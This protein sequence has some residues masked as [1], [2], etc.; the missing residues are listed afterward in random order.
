MPHQIFFSWQSDTRGAIGRFLIHQALGDAI[1]KLKADA[2]IDAAHRE[3]AVDSDT[4][5]IGGSPP[6]VETIFRKIDGALLFVS[7]MTYVG[8]RPGGGGTPNPNV[9][10]EHGWAL[11]S[12]TW[13][14]VISVMNTAM[15]HPKTHELP[16]DLRHA[17][18]PIFFD[19][20]HDA[21]AEQRRTAKDGLTRD[22]AK[23]IR[24]V[25]DDPEV[26]AQLKPAAPVEPHPHDVGLL[27]RA[28]RQFPDG[29]RD[30]L[31]THN[32][33][34]PYR[35]ATVEPLFEMTATWSGAR[36]EFH[37]PEVQAAFSAMRAKAGAFE[38]LLLERTH[39]MDRN[40]EMA[41]PR[42]DQ[43]VQLGLQRSTLDAIKRLNLRSTELA[44]ALDAF[45]RLA[46]ARLRVA[47]DDALK[48][49][50]PDPRVQEAANALYEMAADPH[51][52]A[53][54]EIVQTPRLTVRLAPLAARD[55]TRLDPKRIVK[56]QAKFAP[57]TTQAVETGVDGRQWWSCGPRV[58]PQPLHSPE[59]PWRMRLVRPGDLEFQ[60]RIGRQTQAD[61]AIDIDGLALE[62]LAVTNLERMAAIA[63]DLGFDGPALVQVSFN[64]M[65]EVALRQ[66]DLAAPRRMLLP[67]LGLPTIQ[68]PNL[69]DKLAGPLQDG[70]DRLWQTA[71]WPIGSPSFE[72][73]EWSGYD[74]LTQL[75]LDGI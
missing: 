49:V 75:D 34:E 70:F 74:R 66:G 19:C 72:H 39:A 67:D 1:A 32:F 21:T 62:Q 6:I 2:A 41:W 33:G 16:F 12:L 9:S 63:L 37:D 17:K 60:A 55:H 3:I 35:R 29:L 31:R 53:L 64:G 44:D 43:D 52:G 71:G 13:R 40:T 69:R 65:H 28:H 15:G 36:Y 68:I 50:E 57:P 18:G 22:L 58:R 73:G 23:A 47:L 59:T 5:G 30:L 42:T 48:E 27:G 56:V 8:F 51:R 4:Q 11:K 45:E 25:L 20:P 61:A 10:I 26:H 24:L 7:D 38:E 54:P 14:R 46:S